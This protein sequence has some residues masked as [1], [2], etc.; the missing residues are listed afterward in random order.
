MKIFI[1]AFFATLV[2][3]LIYFLVVGMVGLIKTL[4]YQP[5]L[6][7]NQNSVLLQN[8][9]SFGKIEVLSIYPYSFIVAI[10]VFYILLK[11]MYEVKKRV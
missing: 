11:F 10:I 4:T 9:V 1:Q 8:N 7:I 2:I 3:H 6:T 5:N